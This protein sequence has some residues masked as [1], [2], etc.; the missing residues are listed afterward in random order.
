MEQEEKVSE[1]PRE[2]AEMS[3]VAAKTA[4]P[5]KGQLS[6]KAM[7]GWGS[8]ASQTAVVLVEKPMKTET[9]PEVKQEVRDMVAQNTQL[10]TVSGRRRHY[11]QQKPH[12][13][14]PQKLK[15]LTG[16][17][18]P[19]RQSV[20]T[21]RRLAK[22]QRKGRQQVASGAKQTEAVEQPQTTK[23]AGTE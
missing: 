6:L 10:G 14:A 18:R 11:R 3:M 8:G 22:R 4:S 5:A 2:E 13:A 9:K 12:G 21:A 7:F 15:N 19:V 23:T 1:T 16:Q 17:H 20:T